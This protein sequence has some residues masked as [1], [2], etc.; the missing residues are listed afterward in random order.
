M[1]TAAALVGI[2]GSLF[3]VPSNSNAD[4]YD[5]SLNN[6]MVVL[7][8]FEGADKHDE[9]LTP[10]G[11]VKTTSADGKVATMTPAWFDF[12]ADMHVRFVFD[13]PT[14]MRDLTA[15]EFAAFHLT[16]EEGVKVAIE[17]MERVY[18][19]PIASVWTD[20]VMTVEGKSPALNSSYFLDRDFW[21]GLLKQYPDG[22]VVAVPKRGGLLY[23]PASDKQGVEGL[24]RAIGQLFST[25]GNQRVSSALYLFKDGRWSV[26]QAPVGTK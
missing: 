16:P 25:S 4:D 1:R 20:G 3:L 6:L 5:K 14:T 26:L 2:A 21:V 22:V 8:E 18:G 13:A 24:R 19:P 17:N 11:P 9:K 12:I 15:A 7:R 10:S 23:V